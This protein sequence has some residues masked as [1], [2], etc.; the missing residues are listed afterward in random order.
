MMVMPY[1]EHIQLV[2]IKSAKALRGIL[3]GCDIEMDSIRDKSD[4]L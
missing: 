1:G 4:R 3:K 2:P